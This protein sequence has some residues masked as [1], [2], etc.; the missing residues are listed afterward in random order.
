MSKKV[1]AGILFLIIINLVMAVLY[2]SIGLSIY[3]FGTWVGNI[4][5]IGNMVYNSLHVIFE[6]CL[7]M[8][9]IVGM[10]HMWTADGLYHL[11]NWARTAMI[12]L[13]VFSFIIGFFLTF[14]IPFFG[15]LTFIF[16]LICGIIVIWYLSTREIKKLFQNICERCNRYEIL[17]H[18]SECGKGLCEDCL[19][20][21]KSCNILLCPG[22]FSRHECGVKVEDDEKQDDLEGVTVG[23]TKKESKLYV[24]KNNST[25]PTENKISD[26]DTP[27]KLRQIKQLKDDGVIS[28][29]EFEVKKK[30]LLNRL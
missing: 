13:T 30:E 17:D 23:K 11:E 15:C 26:A 3:F 12:I 20:E 19:K 27:T 21:C 22:C 18:C 14:A 16:F 9:V 8:Y 4:P 2:I 7:F 10:I 25:G 24:R 5:L 28:D 29:E 6:I 1:P